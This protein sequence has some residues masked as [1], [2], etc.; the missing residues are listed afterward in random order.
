VSNRI[1]YHV[2]LGGGAETGGLATPATR[3]NP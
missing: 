1:A 3:S 2:A